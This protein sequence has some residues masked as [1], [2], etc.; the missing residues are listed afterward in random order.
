MPHVRV[1]IAP[2]VDPKTKPKALNYALPFA[3]GSFVC[4][5]DAEDRPEAGQLRAALDAFRSHDDDV[6]CAQASLYIDNATN[7]WLSLG[8][9]AQTPQD[10]AAH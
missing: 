4:V 8:I 2:N 9:M 10:K 5:F 3:R 6:A 1:L 7:S